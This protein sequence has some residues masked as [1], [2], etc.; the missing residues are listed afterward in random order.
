MKPILL[1]FL[2]I[3]LLFTAV[4]CL[5]DQEEIRYRDKNIAYIDRLKDSLSVGVYPLEYNDSVLTVNAGGV[6]QP[7]PVSGIYYRVIK[8]GTGSLPLLGQT[9]TAKYEG[10][11]IDGFVFDSGIYSGTL[12]TSS[13]TGWVEVI[14]RMPIGS[15]WIVYIPYHLGYGSSIYNNIPAYSTLIFDIELK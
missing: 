2:T 10:R 3:A 12:G 4:S 11:L 15:R 1:S 13:I 14:Q 9:F 8:Q 5:D 7:G 6:Y